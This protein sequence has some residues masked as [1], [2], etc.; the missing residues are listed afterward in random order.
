MPTSEPCLEPQIIRYLDD[1]QNKANLGLIHELAKVGDVYIR[2]M[3][4]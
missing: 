3:A 2:Q 1:L 4:A